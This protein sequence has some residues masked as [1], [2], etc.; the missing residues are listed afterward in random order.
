MPMPRTYGACNKHLKE[1]LEWVTEGETIHA[2]VRPLRGTD[3]A[4]TCICREY[5][6]WYFR[7]LPPIKEE[8]RK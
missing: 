2:M 1:A 8:V 5:A 6:E 4:I 7:V 3:P